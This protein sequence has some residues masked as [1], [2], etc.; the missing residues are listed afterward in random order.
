MINN[1]RKYLLNT[2]KTTAGSIRVVDEGENFT[3]K[4]IDYPFIRFTFNPARSTLVDMSNN[5]DP[6]KE[7]FASFIYYGLRSSTD[8]ENALTFA[9]TLVSALPVQNTVLSDNSQLLISDG[10]WYEAIRHEDDKFSVPI[11][12]EWLNTGVI[13]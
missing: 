5:N 10:A 7:G 6:Q 9:E 13:R 2:L 4:N 11:F 1:V 12:V 3:P 8:V